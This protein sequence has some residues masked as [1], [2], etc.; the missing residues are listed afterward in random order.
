[1]IQEI[2]ADWGANVHRRKNGWMKLNAKGSRQSDCT[3]DE[4]KSKSE[5]ESEDMTVF[6]DMM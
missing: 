3:R 2:H 1:M 4:Q 6:S 5:M